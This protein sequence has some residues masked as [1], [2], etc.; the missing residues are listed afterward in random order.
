M[1]STVLFGRG[2]A[3]NTI[4]RLLCLADEEKELVFTIA[5]PE[6][7]AKIIAVLRDAPD[8]CRKVPGVGIELKLDFFTHLRSGMQINDNPRDDMNTAHTLIC[9]IVNAGL[10]DDI[11]QAARAAGARGGTILKARGTG[12]AEDTSFFGITIV[13]EKEL[14][15]ILVKREIEETILAAIRNCPEI[16]QP[17]V[18]IVFALPAEQFF[19]L[20]KKD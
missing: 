7:M 5:P 18:G 3:N 15:L 13:P 12:T 14:L 10:A 6:I 4:L 20:G 16:S 8:L 1:G 11:M 17:G 9:T 19:P 2:T